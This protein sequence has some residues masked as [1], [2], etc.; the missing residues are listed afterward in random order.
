MDGLR[1]PKPIW[2]LKT[3]V[4]RGQKIDRDGIYYGKTFEERKRPFTKNN[5]LPYTQKYHCLY[6]LT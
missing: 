2:S 6:G 4:L 5:K 1:R 3:C